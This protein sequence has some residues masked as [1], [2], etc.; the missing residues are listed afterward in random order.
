[1]R[2][3]LLG[4][5]F[6]RL[7]SVVFVFIVDDDPAS[8]DRADRARPIDRRRPRDVGRCVRAAAKMGHSAPSPNSDQLAGDSYRDCRAALML[9]VKDFRV[10]WIVEI[11]ET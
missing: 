1:M 9:S 5:F 6:D 8:D 2:V 3:S 10:N 4:L 7:I 11:H